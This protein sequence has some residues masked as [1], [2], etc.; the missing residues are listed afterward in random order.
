MISCKHESSFLL[1]PEGKGEHSPEV[2][3]AMLSVFFVK[4][5]DHFHIRGSFEAVAR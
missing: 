5:E 1:I 4:M 2:L 3:D